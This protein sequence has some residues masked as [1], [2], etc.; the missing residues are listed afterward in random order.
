MNIE[1]KTFFDQWKAVV[2]FFLISQSI[3]YGI[4]QL[5]GIIADKFQQFKDTHLPFHFAIVTVVVHQI[6]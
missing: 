2:K 4:P 1:K 5:V 3:C 6:V